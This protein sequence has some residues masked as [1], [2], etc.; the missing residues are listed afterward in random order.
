[1]MSK[2]SDLVQHEVQKLPDYELRAWL[3]K[4]CQVCPPRSYDLKFRQAP[5]HSTNE[6]PVRGMRI[7]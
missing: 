5:D 7:V 3:R 4:V 6:A 1:M 2:N